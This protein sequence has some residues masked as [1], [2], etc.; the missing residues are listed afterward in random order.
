MLFGGA[1]DGSLLHSDTWLLELPAIAP[2]DA[3]AAVGGRHAG[4]RH[5]GGTWTQ[6]AVTTGARPAARS[7]HVCATWAA[8][9]AVVLH[10]G[11]GNDG[12]MADTWVL[13]PNDLSGD[14]GGA[15]GGWRELR[16][17]GAR[18]ARAHHCGGVVGDRLLLHSGQDDSLLTSDTCCAL[19]LP[20]ATWAHVALPAGVGPRIDAAAASLDGLGLLVFG[21][22]GAEFE[23]ESAEP[24]LFPAVSGFSFDEY[25]KSIPSGKIRGKTIP[26]YDELREKMSAA[27]AS[28]ATRTAFAEEVALASSLHARPPRPCVSPW[29]D[30]PRPRAC[31]GMCADGLR[32][33]TFG[34]FDGQSDRSDLWG[35]SFLPCGFGAAAAAAPA[36]AAA[37]VAASGGGSPQ[38]SHA[39]DS[40]EATADFRKRQ[41]R[42]MAE[43]WKAHS[44]EHNVHIP[45]HIRV[46]QAQFGEEA[47]EA[48]A[49]AGEVE[50]T[51][52]A[53]EA[54]RE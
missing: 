47:A 4:G 48:E 37:A 8:G 6:I 35:L 39:F 53:A 27:A 41:Q 44:Y 14:G 23:F 30:A 43:L 22:V 29:R 18:V 46:W 36:A 15:G 5:A 25:R 2:P 16:T 33:F 12:T 10:G 9:G 32:A 20:T 1:G 7:A 21:G 52:T 42:M 26:L 34:G 49:A 38:S 11:L 28:E 17:V 3:A 51:P 24:W 40:A 31:A 19:H 45:L 54:V 13:R 50:E